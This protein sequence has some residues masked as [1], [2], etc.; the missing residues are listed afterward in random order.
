MLLP[1]V[2]TSID[3]VNSRV[4]QRG[5]F[6]DVESIKYNF[7]YSLK[8][9]KEHFKKFDTLLLLDSSLHSN[10]SVPNTLLTIKNN[11]ISFIDA[12]APSRARPVLDEIVQKLTK[13]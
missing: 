1:D 4:D 2:K 3:R 10:L 13:N 11:S 9:L 5:H 7:E 6:V 8:M 12:N